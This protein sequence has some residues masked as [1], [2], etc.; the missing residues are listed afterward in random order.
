MERGDTSLFLG[1]MKKALIKRNT[2]FTLIELLLYLSLAMVMVLVLGGI[3][4][5]V[6]SV[7]TQS[8]VTEK[9]GYNAQFITEKVR[10]SIE[11]ATSIILPERNTTSSRLILEMADTTKNPTI[12]DVVDGKIRI[13]EGVQQP[14]T[15]SGAGV[16]VANIE[17]TNVTAG[18]GRGVIRFI[19][20]LESNKYKSESV[21]NADITLFTTT[22]IRYTP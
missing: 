17:F 10:L 2:G 13:Q 7:R 21:L 12:V 8:E 4:M 15:L 5:N 22:G 14:Y 6:L 3:G 19:L 11:N 18:V 16:S 20:A 9:V 1:S